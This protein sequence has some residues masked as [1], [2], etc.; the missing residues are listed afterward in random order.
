MIIDTSNPGANVRGNLDAI[1]EADRD[2]GRGI[3]AKKRIY[4]EDK[5]SFL[6]E[7]G[8]NIEKKDGPSSRTVLGERLRVGRMKRVSVLE[9]LMERKFSFER[10]R[11]WFSRRIRN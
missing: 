9:S 2:L 8:I 7:M 5:K 4:T 10:E 3:G 1:R 6:S 11:G